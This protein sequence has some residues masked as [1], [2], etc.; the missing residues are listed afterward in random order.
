M[1]EGEREGEWR[2]KGGR[3]WRACRP[4]FKEPSIF[5]C[6]STEMSEN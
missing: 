3:G 5:S 6:I 4:A 2:Q 1:I